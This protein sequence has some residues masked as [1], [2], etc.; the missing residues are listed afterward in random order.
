M[1]MYFVHFYSTM[2]PRPFLFIDLMIIKIALLTCI[3]FRPLTDR[4]TAKI[5]PD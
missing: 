1:T 5:L 4:V 3:I 2:S